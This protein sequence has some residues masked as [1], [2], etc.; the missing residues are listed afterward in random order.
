M[1]DKAKSFDKKS[2]PWRS[3]QHHFSDN[4]FLSFASD[5]DSGSDTEVNNGD[6]EDQDSVLSFLD[7]GPLA[8]SAKGASQ[9][10]KKWVLS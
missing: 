7:K 1:Q 4:S 6:E 3:A 8:N 5:S 10:Q 2:L 9:K